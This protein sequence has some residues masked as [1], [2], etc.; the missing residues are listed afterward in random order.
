MDPLIIG[1]L[2]DTFNNFFTAIQ[3]HACQTGW[4][5]IKTRVFN[6]RVNG[7]YYKYDLVCDCGINKYKKKPKRGV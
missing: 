2:F 1:Q 6:R 7:N 3:N 4:A 5:I